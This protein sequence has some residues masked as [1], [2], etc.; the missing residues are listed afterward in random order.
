MIFNPDEK[1]FNY[2]NINAYLVGVA[3]T[4]AL[5]ADLGTFIE[6]RIFEPLGITSFEYDRCP[7]GYFYGASGMKLTVNE[8]SKV[9]FLYYITLD[10]A[11]YKILNIDKKFPHATRACG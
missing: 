3:L 6:K 1:V 5:G 4:K 10:Y 7:E 2:N 11:I 9:G 8:L